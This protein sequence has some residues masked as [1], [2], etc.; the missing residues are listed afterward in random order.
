MF[1]TGFLILVRYERNAEEADCLENEILDSDL[2]MVFPPLMLFEHF[3]KNAHLTEHITQLIYKTVNNL[4]TFMLDTL[5]IPP[6]PPLPQGI[7]LPVVPISSLR[8]DRDRSRH[9]LV[10]PVFFENTLYAFKHYGETPVERQ[11]TLQPDTAD[12]ALTLEMTFL[13]RLNSPFI[14]KPLFLVTSEDRFRGFLMPFAPAGS[15]AQVFYDIR[16][17]EAGV[18]N[19]DWE[20]PSLPIKAAGKPA[21]STDDRAF[22]RLSP[23]SRTKRIPWEVKQ[24][25]ALD[26][27]RGVVVLHQ[28]PSFCGD[29]KL[30]NTLLLPDGHLCLIDV[31]P[32]HGWTETYLPPEMNLRLCRPELTAARDVFALGLILWTLSEEIEKFERDDVTA[33]PRVIWTNVSDSPPMWYK[34]LVEECVRPNPD[35]RPSADTVL[36]RLNAHGGELN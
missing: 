4:P 28:L 33:A 1:D 34:A 14:I 19:D 20:P 6:Y 31:A 7:N 27:V 13:S 15:L 3:V 36:A 17:R 22:E 21:S 8:R 32:Q 23:A 29:L 26:I 25:W 11:L 5:P 16:R 2:E 30:E 12:D 18:D 10:D 35:E 24:A 9:P